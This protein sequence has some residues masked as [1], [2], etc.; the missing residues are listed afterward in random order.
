MR[1]TKGQRD[2]GTKVG[3]SW[4]GL[5]RRPA[6]GPR[7]VGL[8]GENLAFDKETAAATRNPGA[9]GSGRGLTA[10]AKRLAK[11]AKSD[12]SA[13]ARRATAEGRMAK[14]ARRAENYP[15]GSFPVISGPKWLENGSSHA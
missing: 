12:L 8:G 15:L 6:C 3:E 5:V 14:A 4:A 2:V 7:A 10:P 1:G 13:I 9:P 11:I